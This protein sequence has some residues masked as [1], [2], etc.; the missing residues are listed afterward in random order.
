MT[1]NDVI[2]NILSTAGKLP[3]LA[4]NAEA[5]AEGNLWW[6]ALVT[7]TAVIGFRALQRVL[8]RKTLRN[9]RAYEVLP[10]TGFDP[11]LEDVLRFSRQLAQA[12][13]ST[14]RWTLLPAYASAMRVRLLSDGGPLTLR[15]E[16]PARAA[17]VLR[18]QGYT[19]CELRAVADE[20]ATP[21]RP[22]I[23]LGARRAAAKAPASTP[24]SAPA[25]DA[26]PAAA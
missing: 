16:G 7:V 26:V 9:R 23:L 2:D 20:A 1:T 8:S 4:Q 25:A 14:S 15:V 21:D 6:V 3:Q 17:A 13:R 12:Q 18:H 22:L 11:V 5:W 19:G 24:A 10:T